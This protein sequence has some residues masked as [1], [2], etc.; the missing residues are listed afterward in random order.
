M[1]VR[2]QP[3]WNDP[4]GATEQAPARHVSAMSDPLTPESVHYFEGVR[5]ASPLPA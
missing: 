1:L 4:D 3:R 5:G 2:W